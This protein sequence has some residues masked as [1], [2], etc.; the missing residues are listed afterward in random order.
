VVIETAN[1]DISNTLLQM[2][3]SRTFFRQSASF[4]VFVTDSGGGA[5]GTVI[6]LDGNRQIGPPLTLNSGLA[7]YTTPLTIGIHSFSALFL[8]NALDNGS[9]TTPQVFNTSPRP[10]PR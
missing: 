9:F 8:G 6:L 4:Q 3:P 2:N 1:S 5:V 10:K 7:V